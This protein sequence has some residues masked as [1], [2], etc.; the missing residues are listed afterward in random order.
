M[1]LFGLVTLCQGLV[2][3]YGGLVTARFFL[4]IAETGMFP[5]SFYIISMWYK[6]REAQKRYSFFFSSTTLA[7]AFGGL[8]AYGIGHIKHPILGSPHTGL[9][10]AWRWVFIIEGAISCAL[11]PIWL[12]LIP[13]FPE[14]AKWLSE[15]ERAYVK[16]RLAAD[17]GKSGLEKPI[18]GRDII[19]F[20][21]DY[22]VYLGAGAY[23]GG[24]VSAYGYA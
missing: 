23:F 14:D 19:N 6:R 24:I 15:D 2:K 18:Q 3:S 9:E 21:K 12:F 22:K 4:G 7:G 5:G 20:F 17:Q 8:I 1:F 16:A 10:G 11:A 13:D